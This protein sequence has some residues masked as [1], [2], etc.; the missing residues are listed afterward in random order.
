[1]RVKVIIPYR[2][3]PER[4]RGFRWVCRYYQQRLGYHTVYVEPDLGT[5]P[6]NKSRLINRAAAKFHDHIL[7]IADAD[8]F[9]CDYSLYACIDA[10]RDNFYIPHNVW[11]ETTP[12]Q[13]EEILGMPCTRRIRG[14]L[15]RRNRTRKPAYGGLWVI[16]G[17]L[18]MEHKMDED[19]QG[20]GCEDIEF[21]NRVPHIRINGPLFH[22]Y[23][24][25]ASREYRSRN[26]EL[27]KQ[28]T[29][30]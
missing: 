9:I 6:F 29:N 25:Y 11:C 26:L 22:I 15:F 12:E 16:E 17:R 14:N 1:M 18:F 8:C 10:C 23:H 27:L 7:L 2:L 19:F 28:K 3:S 4:D 30:G 5:D 20:W 21:V 24:P 13:S